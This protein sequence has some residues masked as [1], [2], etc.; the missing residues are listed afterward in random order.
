MTN[1]NARPDSTDP[2]TD[3]GTHTK[4]STDGRSSVK[5]SSSVREGGEKETEHSH[6]R[7][8]CIDSV[9]NIQVSASYYV[10]IL[11]LFYAGSVHVEDTYQLLHIFLLLHSPL[12]CTLMPRDRQTQYCRSQLRIQMYVFFAMLQNFNYL[13]Y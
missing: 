7:L 5:S 13:K 4:T 11:A 9:S 2:N 8:I 1:S 12:P 10:K 6:L 3:T